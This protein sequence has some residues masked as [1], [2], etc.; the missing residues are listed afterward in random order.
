MEYSFWDIIAMFN[1]N[2]PQ[3]DNFAFRLAR[4]ANTPASYLFINRI[5][6][7][8]NRPDW[9][10][11]GGTYQMTPTILGNVQ[12]D[13]EYPPMGNQEASSFLENTTKFAGQMF[14]TE[15]Q[16]RNLIN[17]I[18]GIRITASMDARDA[19]GDINTQMNMVA[20]TGRADDNTINGR[21]INAVLGIIRTI[22]ASHWSTR[23]WLAGEA[24]TEGKIVYRFN[25]VDV[26]VDYKVPATN[27]D[28]YTGNDRFDQSASKWWTW[29]KKVHRYLSNPIFYL[30]STSYYDITEN[31]VNKI[32]SLEITGMTRRLRR[33]RDDAI[34]QKRD[35]RETMSV[36]V[37]DKS[38]S[39]LDAANKRVVSKPF[40]KDKRVIAIGELNADGVEMELGGMTDPD[41]P[42][43]LGYTHVGPT[44]E[45]GGRP[46]IYARIFTPEGKPMQCLAETAA[47]MLP[48][49]IN[50]KRMMIAKF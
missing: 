3:S 5:L 43:R 40:L 49:I 37:Y 39:I 7:A 8:E 28:V 18:N 46:G 12:M 13:T 31:E 26:N 22:Q 41:N 24:L 17:M 34:N 33:Y 27:I 25:N 45:G 30:N 44:I 21:R 2:L 38:G 20:S 19:F 35:V 42:L 6:P 14:F 1:Q 29:V 10:V 23:E 50:S 32:E 15:E 9:H 16:Q 4:I 48:L 47:N 11:T 36:E